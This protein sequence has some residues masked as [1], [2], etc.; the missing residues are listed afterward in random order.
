VARDIISRPL[1]ESLAYAREIRARRAIV[2]EP[3]GLA[4]GEV[5]VVDPGTGAGEARALDELM[6]APVRALEPAAGGARA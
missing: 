5:R 6:A 1:A 4:H 2:I 3:A